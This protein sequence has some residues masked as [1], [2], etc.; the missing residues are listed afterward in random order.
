M[1]IF[2][3]KFYPP[4]NERKFRGSG[5]LVM[6]L[7]GAAV[8]GIT[9]LSLAKANSIAIH[10]MGA[11]SLAMQAQQYAA[12]KAELLRSAKYSELTAQNK[13]NIGNTGFQD[14]VTLGTESDYNASTKKRDVTI[15]VYRTGESSPRSSVVLTRYSKALD[16][17]SSV[18]SGSIIPWYGNQADIPDGFALCNGSN[19]TPDLRDRFIVGAG[20]SYS[21][22]ATGG[23]NTV[24]LTVEQMPSH[25]HSFYSGRYGSSPYSVSCNAHSPG[26][27]L[28]HQ[29]STYSAG[30]NQA[31]ENRPPFY[32]LYYI[33]KL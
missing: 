16:T 6:A 14:E 11:N 15:K 17:G 10:S 2:S 31:H 30:G 26:G 21:L 4:R 33:M 12:S 13:A 1:N 25:S 9:S 29:L 23:A 18:P 24:T 3:Q 22:R 5:L 20:S 32:A 19:G 27:L 28:D 8:V 7:V